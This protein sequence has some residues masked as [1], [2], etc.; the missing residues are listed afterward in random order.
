MNAIQDGLFYTTTKGYVILDMNDGKI[1]EYTE[2]P[3]N[4]VANAQ[5]VITLTNEGIQTNVIAHYYIEGTKDKVPSNVE[6]QVVEDI[7]LTGYVGEKY[8]TTEA[9]NVSPEYELVRIEGQK[10]GTFT[11]QTTEVIY[12]YRLKPMYNYTVEY[13][14]D[15]V[16][17]ESLTDTKEARKDSKIETYEDKIKEGYVFEKTENLPLTIVED[18]SKNV[19]KV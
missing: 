10:E 2:T 11:S 3:S 12:Y 5:Q 7:T 6:G 13:Y 16:K 9:K 19:I 17:D 14:F 1:L 18:T 15:G 8:T 4:L